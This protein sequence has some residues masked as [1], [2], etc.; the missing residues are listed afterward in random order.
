MRACG[1]NSATAWLLGAL[2]FTAGSTADAQTP[3]V[4]AEAI[5]NVFD[6][7]FVQI[8][9]GIRNCP[10]PEGPGYTTQE[11]RLQA[12][13]RAERGTSC[14]RDGRCRLPNA[15]LYDKEIMPRVE[16]AILIDGRFSA[17]SVW[18]EG[19]RRWV[20]LKGC[21]SS[22]EESAALEKLVRNLDDVESVVNELKVQ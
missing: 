3:Y 21:V 12:H 16:K 14:Y 9:T 18:A 1:F 19:Q 22:S 17:T 13:Y 20:T 15:Y 6:D 2:I 11:A 5:K 4:V 10:T 7:P 8:T